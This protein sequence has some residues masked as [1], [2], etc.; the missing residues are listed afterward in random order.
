MNKALLSSV[1]T[2]N[3][4]TQKALAEAIGLSLSRFNAKINGRGGAAFTL[5]EADVIIDRYGLT[6]NEAMNIFFT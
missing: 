1:M 4:D 6:C 5:N 2:K 3:G